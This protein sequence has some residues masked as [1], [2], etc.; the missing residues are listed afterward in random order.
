VEARLDPTYPPDAEIVEVTSSY[1]EDE[2]P[3]QD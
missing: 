2:A 1:E 3:E